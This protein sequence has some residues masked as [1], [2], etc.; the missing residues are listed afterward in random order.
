MFE[1]AER[2]IGMLT[3]ADL[4]T[5]VSRLALAELRGQG[6]PLSAVTA[7][8]DQDAPD[9]GVDVRIDSLVALDVA[10]FVPRR[11]TGFQVK[12]PDMGPAAITK[13]M[14]PKGMLRPVI[15]ELAKA[16]GA[17]V[18]VSAQG[19]VADSALTARKKAMRAAVAGAE[20]TDGLY[21]DFYDRVRLAT[22]VNEHPGVIAWLRDRIGQPLAGWRS[23]GDWSDTG[24][25]EETAYFVSDKTCLVDERSKERE[26]L[27]IAEG[28]VRLR[29]ALREPGQCLRLIG[30][31]GLGKTRLVQ[32]LFESSVGE[33]PLDPGLAVYTDYSEETDPTARDMA[34]ALVAEGRRAILIVDNCN[35]ATH[36][37]LARICS[38]KGSPVSLITVEYDVRDDEPE[39]TEVFRLEAI[40]PELVAS[41]LKQVFSDMSQVDRERIATFSDGNF[42]VARALAETL[43]KGETLGQLKNRDLF[44]RIFDQRNAPNPGLLE[45]AEDLALLYSYDGEDTAQDG[46]LAAI[47]RLSAT[48]PAR[49]FAATAELRRRGL[50]QSRGRWRAILPHAI[51]NPLAAYALERIPPADFDAFC[52]R[53]SPRMLK[54]VSRRLGYLHDSPEAK[55]AVTRWLQP[56][57]PPGDLLSVGQQAM[58][59]LANIAPVAPEI[60]L[61]KLEA[62]LD[63]P[64]GPAIVAPDMPQRDQWI[65]LVKA[66][67]Y[68]P[69]MFES[70]AMLLARLLAGET[71]AQN[72]N[73]AETAFTEL[74][75]LYLSGTRASPAQRRDVAARLARSGDGE[76][77][78][79]GAIALGGLL[80]ASR[81]TS[82]STF[83]FGARSRDWGW[84]PAIYK[85]VWGWHDAAIALA[86]EL[87][88]V[89]PEAGGILG[90]E[91]RDLWH[92]AACHGAI[93]TAATELLE[94]GPWIEGWLGLRAA[95]KYD[96]K[97]MPA[98]VRKRLEKL[99]DHLKPIDLVDQAHAGILS[100]MN[101]GYDI[102]DGEA[103]DGD[104][105]QGWNKA[106][107]Y[108][109]EI[110]KAMAT[111]PEARRIF[112]P[113]VLAEH[114][115]PRA[116]EFGQGLAD[117]ADDLAAMWQEL[118]AAVRPIAASECDTT[119]LGGF[120]YR[121]NKRDPDFCSPVLDAAVTDP[122]LSRHL[123]YFQARVDLGAAALARLRRA[124]ALGTVGAINFF[125]IANG[126]IGVAP[127]RDLA[128]LLD[129]LAGLDGGVERA[130][131]ILHMYFYRDREEKRDHDPRLVAK[132][133]DLLAR[134]DFT[135]QGMLRDY[136]LK[137]VIRIS[138]A[139][140]AGRETA[141]TVCRS[142]RAALDK[143][144][145]SSQDLQYILKGLFQVHP[146]IALDEFLLPTPLRRNR[147][148]LER[149]Y[150]LEGPI[151]GPD[152]KI[153]A[154]W[155]AHDPAV[156]YPLLG[157]GLNLFL[158]GHDEDAGELSPVFLALL[159][160]APDKR[161]FLGNFWDRLHPHGWSGSLADVLLRRRA[162]IKPLKDHP[163]ADVR[164]WVTDMEGELDRWIESERARD[165]R[166]EESFE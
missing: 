13:E 102:V 68:E 4:R 69:D 86:V 97:G 111:E 85:D 17:Y 116:A 21:L 74:F 37:E 136:G 113:E 23:V 101:G 147:F 156:R 18:I 157:G 67:A 158:D 56:N 114:N 84:H 117:G 41:W 145:I 140:D 64:N 65:G 128:D 48:T 166:H 83:D 121:A 9:G 112:V 146:D 100:R 129:E 131:D 79:C 8:G 63:G 1:I 81:F 137:G 60:V 143:V 159:D 45:A 123:P 12:K 98:K 87:A 82:T 103:D 26:K 59:I 90:R 5:L 7:G 16:G 138:L 55:A 19:S 2:H 47:A 76:L 36:A 149:A 50:V 66:L 57:G 155:A 148:V 109:R 96:S 163:S 29:D 151:A 160:R 153:L 152:S 24:V 80:E 141:R 34:R 133:R 28:I 70:A 33:A 11:Q 22:W 6:C 122:D 49:L 75:H 58:D 164:R 161:A 115:A 154:A 150:G 99:I 106:A 54:S 72:Y 118:V 162:R 40:S 165:R 126:L 53:L 27:P 104:A 130:L 46:E 3:D 43:G 39:R 142:I 14:R 94:S 77:R 31:S 25:A 44:V 134:A 30:L 125:A 110:G 51:A 61:A 135:K 91:L 127:A 120:L 32:A 52:A 78:R 89:M 95:H 10:D 71:R 119:V 108:A 38:A 62:E 92:Y 105:M 124:I 20:N 132:G 73:T 35:P 88:P 107:A 93:E 15:S 139:G 144:R 42:R